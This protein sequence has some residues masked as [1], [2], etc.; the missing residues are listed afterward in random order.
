[1]L[2]LFQPQKAILQT[3]VHHCISGHIPSS[4][5]ILF[6]FTLK[7]ITIENIKQNMANLCVP[8]TQ[9]EKNTNIYKEEI[10]CIFLFIS[11]PEGA[12]L[13]NVVFT[14]SVYVF[15]L[16][17]HICNNKQYITWNI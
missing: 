13:L 6:I 14:F 8:G 4:H 11:V 12:T 5:N 2:H 9:N 7:K 16:L 17:L 3:D 15:S 1:M 10:S